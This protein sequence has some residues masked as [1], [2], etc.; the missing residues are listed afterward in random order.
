MVA[1]S[2]SSLLISFIRYALHMA[3]GQP[4]QQLRDLSEEHED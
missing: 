1:I 4:S 3:L 2:I